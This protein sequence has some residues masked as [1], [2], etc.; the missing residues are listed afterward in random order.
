MDVRSRRISST[1][2]RDIL[3]WRGGS[4][5]G[6]HHTCRV[7]GVVAAVLTTSVA[8]FFDFSEAGLCDAVDLGS[9]F[10]DLVVFLVAVTVGFSDVSMTG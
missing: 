5:C 1:H 7:V 2:V 10:R 3:D 8:F 6:D 9:G 4:L